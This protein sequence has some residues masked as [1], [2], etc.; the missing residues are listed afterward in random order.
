MLDKQCYPFQAPTNL[1]RALCR[2]C[3]KKKSS[4]FDFQA[5]FKLEQGNLDE[6]EAIYD[7]AIAF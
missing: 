7:G 4:D 3:Q 1:L 5:E 6:T 2:N